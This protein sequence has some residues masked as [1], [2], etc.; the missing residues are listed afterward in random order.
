MLFKKLRKQV[1]DSE[2]VDKETQL[3][4]TINNP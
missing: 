3:S 2:E 4:L 1:G